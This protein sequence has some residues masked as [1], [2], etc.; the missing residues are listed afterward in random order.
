MQAADDL[1][2]VT[3]CST[4]QRAAHPGPHRRAFDA[5]D[6]NAITRRPCHGQ[7]EDGENVSARQVPQHRSA[8]ELAAQEHLV[9]RRTDL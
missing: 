6:A 9:V 1:E 5:V 7:S 2:L 4:Q 8:G 3:G